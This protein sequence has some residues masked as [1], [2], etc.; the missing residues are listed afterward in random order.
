M[1]K[2]A[3]IS[4]TMLLTL[5]SLTAQANQSTQ[6]LATCLTDSLNG[7]ERKELAKWIFLAISSHSTIKPYS[8]ATSTDID[9]SNQFV[10]SLI[11]RLLTSDCPAQAKAAFEQDGSQAFE[12]AFTVVGEV[13]MQELMTEPSVSQSLSAFEK[14]MDNSKFEQVFNN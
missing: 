13:A 6:M 3:I 2:L 14:Y 1:K 8:K 5:M 12:Q 11:T 7:K 9:K 4:V 10:G